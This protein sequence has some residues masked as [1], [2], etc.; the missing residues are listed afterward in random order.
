MARTLLCFEHHHPDGK[1]WALKH[2]GVWSRH[3]QIQSS[4]VTW[5]TVYLGREARQPKA[6]LVAVGPV[7][8]NRRT[9]RISAPLVSARC[10]GIIPHSLVVNSRPD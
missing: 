6:Y 1:V 3:R 5:Q 9:G 10:F 8:V 4:G 2:G 7:R